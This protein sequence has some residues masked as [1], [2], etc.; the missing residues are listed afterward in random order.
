MNEEL[1]LEEDSV[2][3]ADCWVTKWEQEC[4]SEV[5]TQP[6]MD[7]ILH[8]ER[9]LATQKLWLYFQNSATALAQLYKGK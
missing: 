3:S 4:L 9:D 7:E 2:R 5:D 1:E 6:N 8:N